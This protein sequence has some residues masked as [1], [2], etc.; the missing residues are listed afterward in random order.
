MTDS[1]SDSMLD[2]GCLLSDMDNVSE[3]SSGYVIVDR[4][5]SLDLNGGVCSNNCRILYFCYGID[6]LSIDQI[7]I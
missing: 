7:Q 1:E 6:S 5:G 2:D 4:M 3:E